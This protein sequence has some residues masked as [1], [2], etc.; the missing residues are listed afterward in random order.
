MPM[1]VRRS[2]FTYGSRKKV[3]LSILRLTMKAVMRSHIYVSDDLLMIY[4]EISFS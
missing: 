1:G 3:P 2:V 4:D